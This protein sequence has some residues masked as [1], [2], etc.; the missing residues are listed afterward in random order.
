VKFAVV[1]VLFVIACSDVQ[2]GVPPPPALQALDDRLEIDGTY[3]TEPASDAVFP[4]KVVFLIDLSNSMCYTDP[5]SGACTTDACDQGPNSPASNPTP[6]R[7]MVAVQTV[8]DQFANNPAVS[9]SVVTFSSSVN[10]HP[11]DDTAPSG[12]PIYFTRDQSLLQL[13]SL[14]NVDSVTD[15]QGALSRVR[16]MI[17]DDMAQTAATRKSDLPRTKYAIMFLTDGVPF[18]HCSKGNPALNNPP[19]SPDCPGNPNACTICQSGFNFQNPFPGLTP[20]EDY[21]EPY[22]LVNVVNQIHTLADAYQVGDLK[23]N[24]IELMVPNAAQC[25]PVCFSDDPDGSAAATLL[26]TMAMPDKG[27]GSYRLFTQA[28]DLSFIQYNFTSLSENFVTRQLIVQPMNEV[29][30]PSGIAIDSDGDGISDDDEFKLGSDRL[31]KYSDDDGYSDLFK[32]R[33]PELGLKIGVSS[34]ARCMANSPKCP[35]HLPCDTDGDGLNDCEE[36]EIG[37]DPELIDTDADGIPD[38]VEF[39]LG[40]DPLRDDTHEDLDLDGI[41]NL[42]ETLGFSAPLAADTRARQGWAIQTVPVLENVNSQGQVCYSFTSKGIT[43]PQTLS[44]AQNSSDK[45]RLPSEESL[46]LGW[47]DTYIWVGEAPEGDA[48]DYGRWRVGCVRS[49]WVSPNLRLPLEPN[50]TLVDSDFKD[51]SVFVPDRDCKGAQP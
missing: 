37:T 3:C 15:Y 25:C 9:F 32:L 48:R 43:L 4:V 46:E 42:D 30:T 17:S 1:S 36:A 40:L 2:L 51:P 50:V 16:D 8:L 19:D 45:K 7:R 29:A 39:R 27:L 5:A 23:F 22:Q 38:G 18:P 31:K 21:N 28:S 13:D 26:T 35:G 24:A 20:G 49:R 12:K 34:L 11:L 10:V 41:D 44:R 6:P 47:G 33:H 14:R